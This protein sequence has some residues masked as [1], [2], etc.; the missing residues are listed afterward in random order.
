M[1]DLATLQKKLGVSFNNPATLEQA[2]IHTSYVNEN[3]GGVPG[4][5]ER[6]EFLGDAVLD[7]IV[8]E[9]L[10]QDYPLITEGDMTRFRSA[11]VRRNALARVASELGIGDY[12]YLGKG[13]EAGGG[14]QKAINLEGALEAIVAAVY[15]DRGMEIV[16]DFILKS[17]L[18]ELS[19]TVALN[20]EVDYKS[21]LQEFVQSRQ[22]SAPVYQVVETLGPAHEREFTVE[23]T[24]GGTVLGCGSGRNK[25]LAETEA[26]RLALIRLSVDFTE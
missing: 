8:A 14:R 10:Y 13:E 2:L 20:I 24:V 3:P 21:K 16:R 15:L 22:K 12:L 7:F 9:K 26:A 18:K 5:N 25:K 11:L 19:E 17:I 4:S 23:V 1:A 6:L